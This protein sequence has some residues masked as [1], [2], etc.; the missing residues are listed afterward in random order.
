MGSPPEMATKGWANR[1]VSASQVRPSIWACDWRRRVGTT[2]TKCAASPETRTAPVRY[3]KRTGERWYRP[4]SALLWRETGELVVRASVVP[5]SDPHRIPDTVDYI[6]SSAVI[7]SLF[8]HYRDAEIS[9]RPRQVVTAFA[10]RE[11]H[12]VE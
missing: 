6:T 11:T 8:G 5:A 3:K 4:G 9:C 10:R 12:T 2:S 7:Q 1:P